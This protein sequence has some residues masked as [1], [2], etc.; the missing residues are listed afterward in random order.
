MREHEA[1]NGNL[2][3]DNL[4][5]RASATFVQRTVQKNRGPWIVSAIQLRGMSLNTVL[6]I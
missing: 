3:G 1:E 5:P 6:L 4:V 2:I